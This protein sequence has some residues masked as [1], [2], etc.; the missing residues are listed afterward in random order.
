M[1]SKFYFHL[2]ADNI[3]LTSHKITLA[4][5]SKCNLNIVQIPKV[6]IYLLWQ[7]KKVRQNYLLI[8][9]TLS[10]YHL[11]AL[12][13]N[14]FFVSSLDKYLLRSKALKKLRWVA[15]SSQAPKISYKTDRY[16]LPWWLSGKGSTCQCRRRGFDPGDPGRFYMWWSN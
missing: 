10:C 14:Y 5:K 9:R 7:K 12:F 13:L 8:C 6:Y 11:K 2:L 4:I 3:T 15:H 16:G 1:F